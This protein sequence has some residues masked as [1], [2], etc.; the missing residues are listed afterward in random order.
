MYGK[1][2]FISFFETLFNL[3]FT[4][5]FLFFL[6]LGILSVV[7]GK[8]VSLA[9]SILL[10]IYFLTKIS[11]HGRDFNPKEIKK[12]QKNIF[13]FYLFRHLSNQMLLIYMAFFI[14]LTTIG[15]YYVIQKIMTYLIE[16]PLTSINEVLTSF[17]APMKKELL[18]KYVSLSIKLLF[19]FMLILG[20]LASILVSPL[21]S[22]FFPKYSSGLFLIPFFIFYFAIQVLR[23]VS[24]F[25]R[26]IKKENLLLKSILIHTVFS[27]SLG[28]FLVKQYLIV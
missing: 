16:V 17:A 2:L 25:F 20:F 26:I 4:L 21:I 24:I 15:V 27:I 22:F 8:V 18:S 14:D 7:F 19:I 3:I 13:P 23:P 10:S 5:F 11:F 6:D 9:L 1:V 12:Y 28:F